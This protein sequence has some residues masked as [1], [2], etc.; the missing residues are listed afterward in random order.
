M[1][2][3]DKC[4]VTYSEVLRK[5]MFQQKVFELTI[6]VEVIKQESNTSMSLRDLRNPHLWDT[7]RNEVEGWDTFP[8]CGILV[9]FEINPVGE[10]DSLT[11]RLDQRRRETLERFIQNGIGAGA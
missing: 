4:W 3:G 2:P 8:K 6:P 9:D 11:L 1:T 10:V 7:V 5:R